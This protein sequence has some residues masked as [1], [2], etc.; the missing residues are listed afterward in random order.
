MWV[1][2]KIKKHSALNKIQKSLYELFGSSPKLCNPKVKIKGIS[3][4]KKN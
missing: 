1:V 4:K 2:L 3:S